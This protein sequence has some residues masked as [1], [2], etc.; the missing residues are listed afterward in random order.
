MA[1]DGTLRTSRSMKGRRAQ[2]NAISGIWLVSPHLI[3]HRV[4]VRKIESDVGGWIGSVTLNVAYIRQTMCKPLKRPG[5]V[6]SW[7][8]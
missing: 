8:F 7:Y 1:E 6:R 5:R 2:V 4:L 3:R